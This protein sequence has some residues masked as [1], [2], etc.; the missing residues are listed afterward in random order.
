MD[1]NKLLFSLSCAVSVRV[2]PSWNFSDGGPG[3]V[4]HI[5]IYVA[6]DA[7]GFFIGLFMCIWM[8]ET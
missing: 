6:A 2:I 5:W 1:E 4:I 8:N 3:N 7:E